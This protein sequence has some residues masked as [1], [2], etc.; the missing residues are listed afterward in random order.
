MVLTAMVLTVMPLPESVQSQ[1]DFAAK[2]RAVA[3]TC[4][5]VNF[6]LVPRGI[7][8]D[9]YSCS[10]SK[11]CSNGACC[12]KTGYC[13]YG[14]ASCGT[15]DISPN[16]N[17]WSNCDAKAECGR[18]A[19]T[20]GQ[21]CPLNVCCSQ[22]GFCGMTEEFCKKTDDEE[23]SCQ[24][25]CDQPGSGGSDGDVQ[26]LII[27]YYEAWNHEKNCIGMRWEDIPVNSLTHLN[28]AFGYITPGTFE[29]TGMDDLSPDLFSDLTK[30]KS[31]NTALKTM[32][33]LGGWTFNDNNTATQPVFSDMVSSEENRSKFID[34]LFSFLR[35]Y[36]FD[37]VDFDWEY[38]GAGDRGGQPDDGVNFSQLLKELQERIAGEPTKYIV[39][40]TAPT[41]YWYLRHFDLAE[42][43]KHV[44]FVNVMSYDLHGVW[45]ADN[46]IG[47]QILAHTNLTEIKEA[48]NLFWRNDIPANKI[49]LGLGFYGRSFQLA[50]PACNTP[51]CLFKGGAAP[52]PCTANTGTLSYNEI[53]Q[54]IEENNIMPYYDKENE[55]K[56][57]TWKGDQWISFDD[58]ETFQ[59]KIKFAN[60]LGL[61]GLLIWAVDL[62]TPQLDALSGVIYPK[63]LGEIGAEAST[64]DRYKDAS[65]GDCRVTECGTSS[66]RAGEIHITNQPC[67]R[68]DF[69]T[70]EYKI[71]ALC[72]PLASAPDPNKCTWRG[73]ANFCNGQCHPGEV[74]LESNKWGPD[75]G[76]AFFDECWDG[77]KFYCCEIPDK[78]KY[79]CGWTDCGEKCDSSKQTTMTWAY[80][81]CWL[82]PKEFCCDKEQKWENCAW[83]GKPGSCF[84]NHCDTGHQ[85]ALATSYDGE[86]DDCG[87]K[88]ER[89]RT[90]CCDPPKD[91]SVF[92][93]VPLEYLF[94]HPPEGDTVDTDFELE[95]D[96]TFGGANTVPFAE[97][98]DQ[99]AFGFVVMASPEEIQVSLDKRSGSD[100]EV[101]NCLDSTSIG[102]HTVKMVC[103]DHSDNSDCYK[104][105]LGHGVPGTII[106]MPRGCG[107]G[108]YAVAKTMTVSG[109]QSLPHHLVKRGISPKS[110]IYDLT[111]DYDFK[112]VPRDNAD[113][114]M[115][116]DYS[117]EPG[118]WDRVVDEA[119]RKKRKF[120][121]ELH[122]YAGDHK[123]WLDDA[124]MSDHQELKA[125]LITREELHERWFGSDVVD[126]L[127]GL[128]NGVAG[129]IDVKHSYSEDFKL[130]FLR[131]KFT[132]D[133]PGNG[134]VQ[135]NLD[136]SATVH[137]E[138]DTNYGFTLVT[139]L[140]FPPNLSKSYLYFRNRGKVDAKFEMSAVVSATFKGETVLLSADQ[141]G[142]T[143][144]VPGAVEGGISLAGSFQTQVKLVDW[145]VRQTFPVA[146]NDWNPESDSTPNRDGT[147]QLLDPT[148]EY[149]VAVDGFITAHVKPTITFGIEWSKTL[150]DLPNA[151]V[152]LV[153][154]GYVTFYGSANTGSSGSSLCYGVKAGADLY[155]NVDAPD[156]YG[157]KLSVDRYE[158]ASVPP[159]DVFGPKCPISSRAIDADWLNLPGVNDTNPKNARSY[160]QIF[161]DFD[162]A[163]KLNKRAQPYGPVIKVPKLTCP[164]Q[165]DAPD[166]PYP[167]PLCGSSSTSRLL[168]G[169]EDTCIFTP[170]NSGES[171]CS[172]T[173]AKR[174]EL[175]EFLANAS[176]SNSLGEN[177]F[178]HSLVSR[179]S[180]VEK[181]TEKTLTW[182]Y[183]GGTWYLDFGP[184]PSCNAAATGGKVSKVRPTQCSLKSTNVITPSDHVYEAQTIRDFLEMLRG[185]GPIPLPTAVGYGAA[186][187]EW[188]STFLIDIPG[189]PVA[190][191][192]V[193]GSASLQRALSTNLGGNGNEGLMAILH[194]GINNKKGKMFEFANFDYTQSGIRATKRYQREVAGVFLYMSDD[195]IWPK[196]T[197]TSLGI[198][199]T[200]QAF[201]NTY[202]WGSQPGEE[203]VLGSGGRAAGRG[204]RDLY[205]W[206]IDQ[207]M[208]RVETKYQGW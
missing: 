57:I 60:N 93:P 76:D 113:T 208:N 134:E 53:M 130:I 170:G 97:D 72:C 12:A 61:G 127:K 56:Y 148:F 116:I 182:D 35:N 67:T 51:G 139:T 33:A 89:K 144:T 95:L 16:E 62:D 171:T 121:R 155:A 112:R 90:F 18:Y 119:A 2:T 66:C 38:P 174:S 190:P 87:W 70:G 114:Q 80:Q 96:P 73:N 184:Y 23:T 159:V 37:G 202:N 207:Y 163:S 157:W 98:P 14:P 147:Q 85:V 132:C 169:R 165:G 158:I 151:A 162:S 180:E 83:H 172:G 103:T 198:E 36:G 46:P 191:L 19:K 7:R 168:M 59:A 102:E 192:P 77:L 9:D 99:A 187:D 167:C 65:E 69:V 82:E 175:P 74:A 13:G 52:G 34:N 176:S 26:S 206:F 55:V 189:G 177:G 58:Q 135:A 8:N 203:I 107:P 1:L 40:F 49:N 166:D 120:K 20:V 194:K 137:V 92:S 91:E 47:S 178:A 115:R 105:G 79:N 84:D 197:A 11:P 181:R 6:S 42:S 133:L 142:A 63:R 200:L 188:V 124:W 50:N 199:Q 106:E 101:F 164:G 123:R 141:F 204:L 78:K 10:E 131:E 29:I 17:C 41:S 39:S 75:D 24:S 54:V 108:K 143:F 48:L 30:L 44:D 71:S 109:D 122:E 126:W 173:A 154:D 86:G 31:K 146:N 161:E 110:T 21:K 138:M 136:A 111:F 128:I 22:F 140:D 100:W 15:N 27:G 185:R 125:G 32:V 117:N 88:L 94:E 193:A 195:V 129:G 104:I 201:D 28:F 205:C 160:P 68:G 196:F 4:P 3:E 183:G 25:N 152:N 186:S 179:D 156:L 118:Y 150:F 153:A 64:V 145:D 149:N 43:V 5:T 45:D 81:D